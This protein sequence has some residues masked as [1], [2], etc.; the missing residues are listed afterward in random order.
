MTEHEF[1]VY[2]V[3]AVDKY[4]LKA[5]IPTTFHMPLFTDKCK[6][7]KLITNLFDF[8]G[9]EVCLCWL[10]L[11]QDIKRSCRSHSCIGSLSFRVHSHNTIFDT[12][13]CSKK[14]SKHF[15]CATTILPPHSRRYMK[16]L[17]TMIMMVHGCV[18]Y[19]KLPFSK[20]PSK[21]KCVDGSFYW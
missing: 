13:Y 14:S 9:V 20:T 10:L 3:L 15:P 12:T 11:V 1:Y 4:G 16:I 7:R 17:I 19:R 2:I 6:E 21:Y 8:L 5:K 18:Y